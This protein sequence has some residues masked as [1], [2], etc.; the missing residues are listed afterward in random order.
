MIHIAWDFRDFRIVCGGWN[1]A[2]YTHTNAS[3]PHLHHASLPALILPALFGPTDRSMNQN[4]Y[5]DGFYAIGIVGEFPAMLAFEGSLIVNLGMSV[6]G[7]D[8]WNDSSTFQ[9]PTLNE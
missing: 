4:E 9:G 6:H 1:E 3:P 2:W 8:A 5:Y 7:V